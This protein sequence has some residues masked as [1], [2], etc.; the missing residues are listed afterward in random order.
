[1]LNTPK[2][3]ANFTK[4]VSPAGNGMVTV[5]PV[6]DMLDSP[7]TNRFNCASAMPVDTITSDVRSQAR[8]VR[9]L[10]N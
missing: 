3:M 7:S 9:S 5:N 10:A 1:M 2:G 6:I 4:V 8:K